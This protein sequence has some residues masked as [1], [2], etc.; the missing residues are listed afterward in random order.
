M[1]RRVLRDGLP[2]KQFY[3]SPI[4]S[5]PP[6]LSVRKH[7]NTLCAPTAHAAM[8]DMFMVIW[9]KRIV[10]REMELFSSDSLEIN[11]VDM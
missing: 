10:D 5:P 2:D 8:M 11:D 1:L 6:P 3:F 4:F 7:A 9:T